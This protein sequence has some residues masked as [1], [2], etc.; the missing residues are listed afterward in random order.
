MSYPNPT[1]QTSLPTLNA[2]FSAYMKARQVSL[3]EFAAGGRIQNLWRDLTI[4]T[5]HLLTEIAPEL[6]IIATG[7]YGRC[8]LFPHSDV[9]VLILTEQETSAEQAQTIIAALQTLWDMQIPVSHAARS[10][11]QTIAAA[12]QDHTIAAALMDARLVCGSRPNFLRLKKR[13][14]QDVFGRHAR[15]FVEAKLRE[16]DSRHTKWGDSRFVLE[17]NVKEGKG[18]LRDLHTLNWLVRYCYGLQRASQLVREDLLTR[19]EWHHYR[20]AYM[21]FSTV[22]GHLHRIH[23]RAHERLSF[24]AQLQIAEAMKFPGRTAQAKAEALMMR[25][26]QFTRHVGNLTRVFCAILEEEN[27]RIPQAPF[28]APPTALPAMLSLTNGRINFAAALDIRQTPHAILVLFSMSQQLGLDIHPRAQLAISRALPYC[29]HLLPTDPIANHVFLDILL[30]KNT[31]DLTLRRMND[32]GVLGALIPEF[33]RITGQMQYDGYHTYTVDEHILMAVHNLAMIESGKWGDHLP[34]STELARDISDRTPLYVAMLC[35]DIAKGTGGAHAE[36]GGALMQH[37]GMRLGLNPAQIA[38]AAWLIQHQEL[39]TETA[40]KRDLEDSKTIADFVSL[41]QSPERLRLLLLLT[42]ADVKAVGPSIWNPW[43][44]ALMRSLYNKAM[45]AMGV[46]P[47]THALNN[48]TEH[49]A[50]RAWLDHGGTIGLHMV[51][52]EMRAVTEVHCCVRYQRNVFQL[53]CGA[54]AWM[55]ANIVSA[56]VRM[57]GDGVALVTLDIQTLR[58]TSFAEEP[59]KLVQLP[60][61]I[62]A[63][64]S[65]ALNFADELPSRRRVQLQRQV[66]VEP[67]VYIDNHISAHASVIEVNAR[68]RIGLL[69]DILGALDAC[70]LQVMTAHIAT[71]GNKAVD[72]FYVKDAFGLKL[73]HPEKLVAL[74]RTLLAALQTHA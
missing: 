58:E 6:T 3:A 73:Y 65:G 45:A 28:A 18:A 4:A 36:K 17:P 44:G 26:F 41:V 2:F 42:V 5:D 38:L 11:E 29:H 62:D 25:Y 12:Q 68:D 35:H 70:G 71:Y 23:G 31:G 1:H 21:F 74:Q 24:D 33:S 34:L 48:L 57:V 54:M 9:D 50:Y 63:A 60:E 30:S 47:Q 7:G 49:P 16:R 15:E 19:D 52:D 46:E 37:I 53:L 20:A 56:R 22:R 8:E 13:L 32:M 10:I 40:F 27:L 43:K 69:Y 14:K 66:A 59:R 55:G 39:V 51:H 61:L 72:V 64:L 67:S